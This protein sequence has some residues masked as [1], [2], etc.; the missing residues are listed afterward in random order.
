MGWGDEM[1]ATGQARLMHE[2]DPSRKVAIYDRSGVQRKHEAW[3]NNPHIATLYERTNKFQRL[4]NGPGFRPY[5]K[6]KTEH[7]WVWNEWECPVGE[8]YFSSEEL[9]WASQFRP[10]IIIEPN[11]KSKASSNKDWGLKNWTALAQMLVAEGFRVSQLGPEGTRTIPC[12]TLIKT[13]TM[14]HACAVLARAHA[15]VL[16]EGGLHHSAAALGIKTVVIFG[17]YISPKQ[18]GYSNQVNMFT[19]GE[20]CGM[21]SPCNHCRA[22]MEAIEPRMIVNEVKGFFHAPA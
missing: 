17:G 2:R 22:A 15:A 18:T 3:A 14:R 5:I 11:L 8:L 10:E 1:I 6:E 20:P 7:R 4:K 13:P 9:A 16:P 19:G 21:R 12:T